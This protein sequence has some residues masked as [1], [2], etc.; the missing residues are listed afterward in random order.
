MHSEK[1]LRLRLEAPVL[2]YTSSSVSPPP[3]RLRNSMTHDASAVEAYAPPTRARR[4]RLFFEFLLFFVGAP[5]AM[6]IFIGHYSLF[7]VLG[8]FGALGAVLLHLTPGFH[9]RELLRGGLARHVAMILAFAVA[10]TALI[11]AVVYLAA[12]HRFLELPL[13]RTELWLLIMVAYPVLSVIPQELLYRPLFFRRYGV[14]FPSDG[15]AIAANAVAFGL[16]HALYA[17]PIAIGLTTLAGGVFG[18][19]YVK[20][21]SFPLVCVLH[22]LAGQLVFTLGLGIYFYHGAAG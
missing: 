3:H 7:A 13:Y 9:W 22:A 5:T 4:V 16:G 14:L 19:V 11:I 6:A 1:R 10:S 20:T 18:W 17:N 21:G 8:A 15:T 2:R 12:P